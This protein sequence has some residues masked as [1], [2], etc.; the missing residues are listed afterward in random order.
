[1]SRFCF[2]YK[3]IW[4]FMEKCE[5]SNEQRQRENPWNPCI[6]LAFHSSTLL[7]PWNPIYS[8]PHI[9][10]KLLISTD[11]L[12]AA[13]TVWYSPSIEKGRTWILGG[14]PVSPLF[15]CINCGEK[16]HCFPSIW[17][18]MI[19][20]FSPV[21]AFTLSAKKL[22]GGEQGRPLSSSLGAFACVWF[23]ERAK[24]YFSHSGNERWGDEVRYDTKS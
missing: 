11:P 5:Q 14:D 21:N 6:F 19:I 17:S 18:E 24:V 2:G 12:A 1:M 16:I 3:S 10:F 8:D 7:F 13:L 15:Q 20:A 22:V 4:T 23:G 9:A